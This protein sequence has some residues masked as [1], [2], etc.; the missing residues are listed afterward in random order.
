MAG[1]PPTPTPVLQ[2]KGTF[3]KDRHGSRSDT[4]AGPVGDAPEGLCPT[5]KAEWRRVT[6]TLAKMHVGDEADMTSLAAYCRTW[7]EW[8]KLAK[9]TNDPNFDYTDESNRKIS[10]LLGQVEDRLCKFAQ[11]F[12]LTPS[13]RARIHV[14]TSEGGDDE[15]HRETKFFGGQRAG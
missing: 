11:Q 14:E 13:S 2:A 6:A 4:P 9:I 12:G 10:R 8:R 15:Q 5:A 7:A 3:R 1:R